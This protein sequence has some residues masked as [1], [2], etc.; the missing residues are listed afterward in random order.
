MK[1]YTKGGDAGETGLLG[2]GR[3]PKSSARIDAIGSVDEA[4]AA[5][6][7]CRSSAGDSSLRAEIESIQEW[8]FDLGARLAN[9]NP[10]DDRALVAPAASLESSIDRQEEE[11]AP[12]RQFILPGGSPFASHLH[13]AR[14]LIRRAERAVLNLARESEVHDDSLI[15]LNRLSDWAF[16]A[17]RTANR[18]ANVED[19]KWTGKHRSSS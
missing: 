5:L 1:I 16:V 8:L 19:I 14:T 7:L 13:L 4:N 6:G 15:F 9:P 18:E 12:L 2:G 3:I 11:L 10:P 17:A